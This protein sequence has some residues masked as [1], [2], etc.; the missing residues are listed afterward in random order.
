[1]SERDDLFD[2]GYGPRKIRFLLGHWA[3]IDALV[4]WPQYARDA[5]EGL[6]REWALLADEA[7]WDHLDCLCSR[8]NESPR[9]ARFLSSTAQGP[10]VPAGI[11]THAD[12]VR[13]ADRLPLPWRGTRHVYDLMGSWEEDRVGRVA[14][15]RRLELYAA[16]L[17]QMRS[18]G[19][20]RAQDK[21]PEPP[22]DPA[23]PDPL[24]TGGGAACVRLMALDLRPIWRSDGVLVGP[25]TVG[26]PHA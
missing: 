20:P 26:A 25:R 13:A 7:R 8:L 17:A 6:V 22:G 2:G 12:I 10:S 1:M 9:P 4:H 16:R 21:W 19:L 5:V 24:R 15:H 14:R 11:A 3:A 18:L 23:E